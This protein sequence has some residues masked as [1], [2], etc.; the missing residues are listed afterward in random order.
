MEGED[1][2]VPVFL[3]WRVVLWLHPSDGQAE[4]ERPRPTSRRA[5]EMTRD[6]TP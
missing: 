3:P 5:S 1:G 6:R 4:R 2:E